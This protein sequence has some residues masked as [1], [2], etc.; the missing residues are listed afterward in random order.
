MVPQ[1]DGTLQ[2]ELRKQQNNELMRRQFAEKANSV[3]P[4]IERQMDAVASIAMGMQVRI[5]FYQI[6]TRYLEIYGF[7]FCICLYCRLCVVSAGV[8]LASSF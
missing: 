3:G 5:L 8:R 2:Q 4:W 6:L 1:R 7:S